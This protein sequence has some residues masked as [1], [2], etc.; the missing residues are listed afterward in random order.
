MC[1]YSALACGRLGRLYQTLM[2]QGHSS[3]ELG[4]RVGPI[5]L[6]RLIQVLGL[7]EVGGLLQVIGFIQDVG[8]IQVIGL[9][10]VFGRMQFIN[11]PSTM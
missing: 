10:K 9:V 1:F 5:L 6:D 11:G 4:A 3:G 7:I 2:P 8:L